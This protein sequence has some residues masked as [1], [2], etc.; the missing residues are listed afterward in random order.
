VRIVIDTNIIVAQEPRLLTGPQFDVLDALIRM[1]A[2]R[3]F[4]PS[5]VVA[6]AVAHYHDRL[7][8][9]MS[10]I[11]KGLN[12][13]SALLVEPMDLPAL[14]LSVEAATAAYGQALRNRLELLGATILDTH[15]VPVAALEERALARRKPFS[16][17]DRGFRDA[18]IWESLLGE[19]V[20]N[21]EPT[22]L[23]TANHRDFCASG[24]GGAGLHP[25]LQADL[26]LKGLPGNCVI[27]HQSVREFV[28][29]HAL[30]DPDAVSLMREQIESGTCHWFS[31]REFWN[32]RLDHFTTVIEEHLSE[33]RREVERALADQVDI[34][35]VEL[36]DI[37]CAPEDISVSELK[38]IGAQRF[39]LSVEFSAVC[40]VSVRFGSLSLSEAKN[41]SSIDADIDDAD[42]W[43][44]SVNRG[45]ASI[46]VRLGFD[47]TVDTLEGVQDWERF[48][49][50][51]YERTV[52]DFSSS[53]LGKNA[54]VYML[55]RPR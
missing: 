44:P 4:V 54:R 27:I 10:R 3:L 14:D 5:V 39:V 51:V 43:D 11:Q 7:I 17:S 40:R 31:V 38:Q 49:T 42:Y 34:D 13:L 20:S 36:D 28:E 30:L 45:T 55:R 25:D 19:V 21:Q 23:I 48:E 15:R 12:S 50:F 47:L 29:H 26:A 32:L 41:L 9:S 18:L 16:Q 2:A 46:T 1:G 53:Q 8:D 22:I 52:A 6:E 37:E 33:N 24:G 35:E